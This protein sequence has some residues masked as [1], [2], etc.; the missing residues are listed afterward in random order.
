MAETEKVFKRFF[1]VI[2]GDYN[3]NEQ[4]EIT[5]LFTELMKKIQAVYVNKGILYRC[6]DT[7]VAT[8]D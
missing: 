3:K 5:D 1:I 2:V 7:Y 6:C 8:V 4:E